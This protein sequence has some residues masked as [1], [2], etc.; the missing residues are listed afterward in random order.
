MIKRT[1]ISFILILI[2]MITIMIGFSHYVDIKD[3]FF[4]ADEATI[5]SEL[6][7]VDYIFD[8][9]YNYYNTIK[10]KFK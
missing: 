4:I 6:Q 7:T 2:V 9:N 1:L 3:H 10:R 5:N 8:F